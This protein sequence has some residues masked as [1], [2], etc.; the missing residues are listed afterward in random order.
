[1]SCYTAVEMQRV[2]R[3]LI[4]CRECDSLLK[5]TTAQLGKK[6]EVI[7][8]QDAQMK[9]LNKETAAKDA[10]I[11]NKNIQIT[12]RDGLIK[13]ERRRKKW[14]LFGWSVSTVGLVTLL[15]LK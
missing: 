9:L 11:V 4:K 14:A 6:L 7:L 3:K 1:M 10:I 12:E 15:V 13:K 5:I 2:D 8:D